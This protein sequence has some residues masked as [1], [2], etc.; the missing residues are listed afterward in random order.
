MTAV[1]S[2][3]DLSLASQSFSLARQNL[4]KSKGSKGIIKKGITNIVGISLI[5]TQGK[6]TSGL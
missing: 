3:I 5:K 6:L 2:L 1:K 4:K